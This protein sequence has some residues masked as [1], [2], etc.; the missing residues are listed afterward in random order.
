MG[1][2]A[3]TLVRPQPGEAGRSAQLE[4]FGVLAPGRID[5]LLEP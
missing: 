2:G 5:R 3:L 4:G 1:L